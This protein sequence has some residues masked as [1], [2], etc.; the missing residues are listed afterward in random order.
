LH[1]QLPTSLQHFQKIIEKKDKYGHYQNFGVYWTDFEEDLS[2]LDVEDIASEY[3]EGPDYMS[4]RE[5]DRDGVIWQM[6]EFLS[7]LTQIRKSALEDMVKNAVVVLENKDLIVNS[8]FNNNDIII[9]FNYTPTVEILY[10]CMPF[11]IH[12]R[13]DS[14]DLIFGFKNDS[15]EFKESS[16]FFKHDPKSIRSLEIELEK[17]IEEIN[18]DSTLSEED[19]KS[20]R[21][22]L[23]MDTFQDY[24][25]YIHAQGEA[26]YNFTKDKKKQYQYEELKDFL[27]NFNTKDE[28]IV[29]VL[30]HQMGEIDKEYFEYI[31]RLLEPIQWNITQYNGEPCDDD[32]IRRY[33][34]SKKKK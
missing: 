14:D 4:D 24:D 7:E 20:M 12:G 17:E 9:N 6:E 33:S 31:E 30:G 34:F 26:I 11:Y 3:I 28:Y 22:G 23:Y 1:H 2:N 5:S 16:I 10:E 27:S 18:K 8:I 29:Y 13:Y 15:E 25:Y 21:N 19:K 32:L